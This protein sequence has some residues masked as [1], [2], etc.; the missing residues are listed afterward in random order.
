[1]ATRLSSPPWLPACCPKSCR[2]CWRRA[3]GAPVWA[4]AGVDP[5]NPHLV[6]AYPS[7]RVTPT[8]AHPPSPPIPAQLCL[9]VQRQEGHGGGHRPLPQGSVQRPPAGAQGLCQLGVWCGGRG[10]TGWAGQRGRVC[11][12]VARGDI[13]GSHSYSE[14]VRHAPRLQPSPAASVRPRS[15]NS[16]QASRAPLWARCPAWRSPPPSPPLAEK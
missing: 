9:C 7:R 16:L 6:Y 1:M 3:S 11:T 2:S 4:A 10:S 13:G 14:H 15:P 12:A 8:A 5:S